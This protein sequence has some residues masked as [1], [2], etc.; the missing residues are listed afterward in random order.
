MPD[1]PITI[2]APTIARVLD[3]TCTAL[4]RPIGSLSSCSVG[5]RLWIREHFA[6]PRAFES[7]SPTQAL[8]RGATPVWSIDIPDLPAYATADLGRRRFARELPR[9]WHRAHCVI[10]GLRI[11]RISLISDHEIVREGFESRRQ[12][13]ACWDAGVNFGPSSTRLRYSADP[14]VLVVIFRCVHASIGPRVL[15][16][17][18][19]SE[20]KA[21]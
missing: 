7:V 15:A 4:R 18:P 8:E 10:E 12:W 1:L 6:L 21:A 17:S 13:A 2:I 19:I 11:E 9:A 16:R 3:G 20:G 5:D 14:E